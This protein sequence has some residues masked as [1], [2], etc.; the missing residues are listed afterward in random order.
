M[1]ARPRWARVAFTELARSRLESISVPSR[2]KMTRLIQKAV[3]SGS[4]GD[5]KQRRTLA[6]ASGGGDLSAAPCSPLPAN[7]LSARALLAQF[8]LD[9]FPLQRVAMDSEKFAG[10]GAVTCRALDGT[11]DQRLLQDLHCFLHEESVLQEVI[12]D[13]FKC[14]FHLTASNFRTGR[15]ASIFLDRF[16]PDALYLPVMPAKTILQLARRKRSEQ[17]RGIDHV[18]GES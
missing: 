11:R 5:R 8:V 4:P 12:H 17:M 3:E 6:A 14:F 9:D 16:V 2:S 7:R 15:P 1:G 13:R 18:R 10:G